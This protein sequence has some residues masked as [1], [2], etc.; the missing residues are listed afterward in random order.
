MRKEEKTQIT[1]DKLLN[2]AE[3]LMEQYDDPFKV[4]S[5]Q[6]AQES[7][8]QAAMINY[9]FGSRENLIYS[10]FSLLYK[11]YLNSS[12]VEEIIN[13]SLSPKDVLK[14]LHFLV[15]KCLVD[16][17]KLTKAITAFVLFKRDLSI[18]S[19]SFPYVYKHFNGKKTPDECKLI[20]YELSTMMQIIVYRKDDIKNA[21]GFD[22]NNDDEL[23]KLINL[24]IDSLL[25]DAL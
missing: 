5:R 12:Q 2:A 20:A 6:I 10:A 23:K 4:T 9:C 25:G 15:A 8:M 22:I 1:K 14:S 16:N 24:R 3:K 7:G 19:F 11:N 17:Y 18:D 13:S 21:F